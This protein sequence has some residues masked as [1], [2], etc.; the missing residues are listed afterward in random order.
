MGAIHWDVSALLI[1]ILTAV[2]RGVV[3]LT[4]LTDAKED[5]EKRI[6][7]NEG[8]ILHHRGW[9]TRIAPDKEPDRRA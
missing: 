9:L 3:V 1:A 6:G 4:R 2:I 5:H 7:A 8:E